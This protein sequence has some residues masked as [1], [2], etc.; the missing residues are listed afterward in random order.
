ME[1]EHLILEQLMQEADEELLETLVPLIQEMV[2]TVALE[3]EYRKLEEMVDL[4]ELL[5]DILD[6]Q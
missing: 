6:Q 5:L 4:E 2:A 3:K 1:L